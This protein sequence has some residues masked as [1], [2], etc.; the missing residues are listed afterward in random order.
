MDLESTSNTLKPKVSHDQD[1][2]DA[3]DLMALGHEQALTRKFSM[4]SML[5]LGFC[6]LGMIS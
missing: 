3:Q 2:Q 5:A 4:A 1:I 6:V